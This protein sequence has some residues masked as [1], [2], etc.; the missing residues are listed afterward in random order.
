MAHLTFIPEKVCKKHPVPRLVERLVK[1]CGADVNSK[2]GPTESAKMGCLLQISFG[3]SMMYLA[4]SD[5]LIVHICSLLVDSVDVCS[6][7]EKVDYF[8]LFCMFFC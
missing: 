5:L 3:S 2:A 6:G 7:G 8:D 4:C 1:E